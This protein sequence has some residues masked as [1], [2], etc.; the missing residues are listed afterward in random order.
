MLYYAIPGTAEQYVGPEH[1]M[2]AGAVLMQSE[3]PTPDSVA[4]SDGTWLTNPA[5]HR[6]A[7]ILRELDALDLQSVRPV[8]AKLAG[9][10]TS[11]DD[12]VLGELDA[13][14]VALRTELATLT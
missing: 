4:M 5:T 11:E 13:R 7:D 6:R 1:L 2:P 3:R 10:G 9:A 12:R 14:A 8:R